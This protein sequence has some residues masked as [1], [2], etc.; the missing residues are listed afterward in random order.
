MGKENIAS[1]HTVKKFELIESYVSSWIYKLLGYSYC[2][3]VVFIDCMCNNGI[4]KD[5]N[6]NLTHGTPIRVSKIISDAMKKFPDKKAVLYFNDFDNENIEELRKHLPDDTNNFQI[7]LSV[8]D[9][10]DLLRKLKPELLEKK[11]LNYLLFY[12]PFKAAI[13]WDALSPYFFGWGEVIL[14]HMVSDTERAVKSATRFETIK[15][16]EQ[17]YLTAIENLVNLQ[18]DKNAYNKLIE[19]IIKDLQ[20]N[21]N[22]EYYLVSVPFFI[23]TN[24]RIYNIIFFTKNEQGFKLFKKTAWKI[25]GG[26]SSNQNTHG[27]ENQM[28]LD[29]EIDSEDKQCYYVSDI[30]DYIFKTFKDRK[31]VSKQE[32]WDLIEKPPIFPCEDYKNE[33]LKDLRLKDC[34]V[35]KSSVDFFEVKLWKK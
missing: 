33:I 35:H 11:N 1:P 6:E 31:N 5:S 30:A 15:K 12:D 16:Y 17:T 3:N 25:F 8:G 27:K 9:G 28:T 32:I 21:S 14:N 23:K 26:K 34:Q 24:S 7:N 19:K 20:S 22:R 4:Y 29:F 10:N 2:K 13:D 18:G